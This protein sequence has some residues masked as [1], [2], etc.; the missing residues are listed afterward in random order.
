MKIIWYYQTMILPSK[1]KKLSFK[2]IQ[3]LTFFSD[4]NPMFKIKKTICNDE[5]S[6]AYS[7]NSTDNLTKNY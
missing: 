1:T 6:N 7:F 4:F 3:L 5:M 2:L